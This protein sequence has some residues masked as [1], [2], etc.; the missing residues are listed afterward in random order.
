MF[1]FAR[2][3]PEVEGCQ[4]LGADTKWRW[5]LAFVAVEVVLVLGAMGA[6]LMLR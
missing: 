1:E 6:G 3:E 5:L 2:D 4:P